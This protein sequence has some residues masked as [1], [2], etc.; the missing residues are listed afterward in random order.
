[1]SAA[2]YALVLAM[3]LVVQPH[4]DHKKLARAIADVVA[5]EAPLFDDDT[6][7]TRTTALVVAIAFRESS[8]RDVTSSTNDHCFMQIHNRPDL[9]GN[10]SGCVRAGLKAIRASFASCHSLASYVGGGCRNARANRISDDRLQ[11]A[12]RLLIETKTQQQ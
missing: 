8:F 6:D 12:A 7:R 4:G 10:A 3:M 9:L 11:L 1:M 5:S 2:L